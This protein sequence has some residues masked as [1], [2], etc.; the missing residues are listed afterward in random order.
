M[1]GSA[2]M[3]LKNTF[4]FSCGP[5]WMVWLKGKSR[6]LFWDVCSTCYRYRYLIHSLHFLPDTDETEDM[7]D[8]SSDS[9]ESGHSPDGRVTAFLVI[10]NEMSR[11]SH[12]IP[13][14]WMSEKVNW[15]VFLIGRSNDKTLWVS[16]CSAAL[17][18][19]RKSGNNWVISL[20][21]WLRKR[22]SQFEGLPG[23]QTWWWDSVTE[24]LCVSCFPISSTN[25][26]Q[27]SSGRSWLT[28]QGNPSSTL[29]R[30]GRCFSS[31]SGCFKNV[32][33]SVSSTF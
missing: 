23:G 31:Y 22:D 17:P 29:R 33:L 25:T 30:H 24:P 5:H 13:S 16:H 21:G 3:G 4:K 26:W 19:V 2:N 1:R 12:A 7:T 20:L 8:T 27:K 32:I 10:S 28:V 18:S 6:L 15:R 9:L 14:P 11:S